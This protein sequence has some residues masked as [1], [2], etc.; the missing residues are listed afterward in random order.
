L[1]DG[2]PDLIS[3]AMRPLL[4]DSAAVALGSPPRTSCCETFLMTAD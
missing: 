2:G 1:P 4:W 3:L